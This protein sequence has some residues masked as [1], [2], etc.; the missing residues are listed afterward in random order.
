M[1]LIST[2]TGIY[3]LAKRE[4]AQLIKDLYGIDVGLGSI[5]NIEERVAKALDPVCQKIHDFIINSDFPKYFDETGWRNNGKKYF[6]WIATSEKVAIYLIDRHRNKLAFQKLIK[7]QDMSNKSCVSDRY[8][9]YKNITNNHQ[10]CLAHL[11]RDFRNFAQRDGP[12][13]IIGNSLVENLQKACFIHSKYRDKKITLANRNRQLGKISKKVKFLLEDGYA[14]GSDELYGLCDRL[15][16]NFKNLWMFTKITDMEP[17]NN[18]AERDLRKLVIWRKK[19][20]G[21]RS[22]RGINFVEKITTI[23]QSLRKQGKNVLKF[24]EAV[25]V[26]FYC[27]KEPELINSLIRC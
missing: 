19:S 9:V 25:L 22:Q 13:K 14:N 15:L 1:G 24:I 11:I 18:L 7:N 27:N 17:T 8:G 5:P 21:T 12:D 10:F 23:S 2:L 4:A 16:N 3:H 26:H 6:A 20:Y